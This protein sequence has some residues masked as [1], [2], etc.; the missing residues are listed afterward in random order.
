MFL[1]GVDKTVFG[2]GRGDAEGMGMDDRG[3]TET[4]R[5]MVSGK[6]FGEY[7]TG[8]ICLGSSSLG[9][10][11]FGNTCLWERFEETHRGTRVGEM[12][13]EKGFGG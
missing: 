5:K 10:E 1:Q 12:R 7:E 2:V 8:E 11:C 4:L 6:R 9:K 3:L 13:A